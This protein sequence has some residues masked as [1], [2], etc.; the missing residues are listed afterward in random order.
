MNW[1]RRGLDFGKRAWTGPVVD[2]DRK[3]FGT[4][5]IVFSK[6]ITPLISQEPVLNGESST[7]AC[8]LHRNLWH[9]WWPGCRQSAH[10]VAVAGERETEGTGGEDREGGRE[11]G[12]G[13]R[14]VHL[15]YL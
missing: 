9:C 14:V 6:V 11:G 2:L 7:S 13:R 1:T 12:T 15:E 5:D 4:T 3:N 8:L 10:V